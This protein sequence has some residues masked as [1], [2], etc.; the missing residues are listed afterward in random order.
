MSAFPAPSWTIPLYEKL[1][2]KAVAQWQAAARLTPADCPMLTDF[3]A[4]QF[5]LLAI[6]DRAESSREHDVG[7]N[8]AAI[9]DINVATGRHPLDGIDFAGQM[10]FTNAMRAARYPGPKGTVADPEDFYSPMRRMIWGRYVI[11]TFEWDKKSFDFYEQ[12]CSWMRVSNGKDLNCKMGEVF[13]E[14]AKDTDFM[15]LCVASSGNKSFHLHAIHDTGPILALAPSLAAINPRDGLANHWDSLGARIQ[16]ILR[17]EHD[18]ESVPLDESLRDPAQYRRLPFGERAITAKHPS[19]FGVAPGSFVPQLVFWQ[20]YVHRRPADLSRLFLSARKFSEIE[21][22]KREVILSPARAKRISE[23]RASLPNAFSKDETDHC[24][25]GLRELFPAGDPT[26]PE[27]AYLDWSSSDGWRAMFRNHPGDAKPASV[28]RENYGCVLIQGS[29]PHDLQNQAHW[30]PRG[31]KLIEWLADRREAM[32]QQAPPS[33][34]EDG[35]PDGFYDDQDPITTEVIEMGI[36]HEVGPSP[37]EHRFAEEAVSKDW[38]TLNRATRRFLVAALRRKALWIKGPEGAGKTTV[39]MQL[40]AALLD[41]AGRKFQ[42]RRALLAFTDYPGAHEKCAEYNSRFGHQGYWGVVIYSFSKL[43]ERGLL[44]LGMKDD[45]EAPKGLKD[46]SITEVMAAEK[47]FASLFAAIQQL[48]PQVFEWMEREVERIFAEV[49]ADKAPVFFSVHEVAQMWKH[50]APSRLIWARHFWAQLRDPEFCAKER[51]KQ[52]LQDTN[53]AV[54]VHDEVSAREIVALE[55]F[56]VVE[57]VRAMVHADPLAWDE[58]SSSLCETYAAYL[59]FNQACPFPLIRGTQE[60]IKFERAREIFHLGVEQWEALTLSDVGAYPDDR[61]DE[62]YLGG[63]R[64][65]QCVKDGHRW[66]AKPTMWWKGTYH[67]AVAHN[68]IV[69]TTEQ[70]PTAC[71]ERADPETFGIYSLETPLIARDTVALW[72]DRRVTSK[73]M[74]ACIDDWRERLSPGAPE[75]ILAISD[76]VKDK[77]A[78]SRTH[79]SARG[80]NIFIGARILQTM[81]FLAPEAHEQMLALNAYTAREDCVSLYHI[82][83]FNQSAGRNM[84]F[85]GRDG[86]DH[87]LLVNPRLFDFMIGTSGWNFTRYDILENVTPNWR[88]HHRGKNKPVEAAVDDE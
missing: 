27:F 73:S 54:M 20:R 76:C 68:L 61:K 55:K 72:T 41:E 30:L 12:Q 25:R 86:A 81:S 46:Q 49:P 13:K 21:G 31:Q 56:E 43:Y 37:I 6:A 51:R 18:G 52:A 53:L 33:I 79:K 34:L 1:S 22:E 60:N 42:A 36:G 57:W 29:N 78:Q 85:R 66:M 82:D 2:R 23:R 59:A 70:I 87:T 74:H 44:A 5:E 58:M 7:L 26:K 15:G 39:L 62:S 35:A 4:P 16:H 48:Q 75:K 63:T 10:L 71:I 24:E 28:I 11:S 14:L 65:R 38:Q 32:L 64:Y 40:L 77:V 88:K 17:P 45:P 3:L 19:F 8:W 67:K 9:R 83:R 80:A 69:L 84:G 50:G 47:K